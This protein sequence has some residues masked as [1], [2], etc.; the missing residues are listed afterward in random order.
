MQRILANRTRVR[1]ASAVWLL[2]AAVLPAVAQQF[3]GAGAGARTGS[4]ALSMEPRQYRSNTMLG[5]ALI[6][7]DPE[8]RSLVII[9]D[10][11]THQ[12]MTKIISTLDRPKPQVLIKVLF[13]EVTHRKAL[14]VGVE[15]SYNYVTDGGSGTAGTRF[16]M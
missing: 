7:T 10:A 15:G 6:Q 1:A 12:E 16:G 13:L 3:G 9:T 2:V 4:G 14:D 8:T 5:D 11:A